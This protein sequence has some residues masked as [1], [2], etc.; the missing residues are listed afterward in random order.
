MCGI[1]TEV[2]VDNVLRFSRPEARNGHD[3]RLLK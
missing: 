2:V 1:D 3:V